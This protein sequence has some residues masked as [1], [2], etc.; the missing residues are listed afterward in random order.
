LLRTGFLPYTGNALPMV[1]SGY[2]NSRMGP[3]I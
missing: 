2:N 3:A 1:E